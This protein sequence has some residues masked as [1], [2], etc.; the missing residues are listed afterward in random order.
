[1]SVMLV[2]VIITNIFV[3]DDRPMFEVWYDLKKSKAFFS[4]NSGHRNNNG[5]K[6]GLQ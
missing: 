1:M 5:C 3:A 4:T 2:M 6:K